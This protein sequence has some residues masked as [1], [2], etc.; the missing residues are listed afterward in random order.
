MA[1]YIIEIDDKDADR[2]ERIEREEGW[3]MSAGAVYPEC[4]TREFVEFE[5]VNT[6]EEWV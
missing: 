1:R 6:L 5:I 4:D 3:T 2:F